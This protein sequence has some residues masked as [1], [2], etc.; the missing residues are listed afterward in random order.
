MTGIT[1]F[2]QKRVWTDMTF[3][4]QVMSIIHF[5]NNAVANFAE[6]HIRSDPKPFWR[7]RGTK[8]AIVDSGEN[9]TA[10]YE[11]EINH[12]SSGSLQLYTYRD[13]GSVHEQTLPYK[14]SDWHMFYRDI[15]AHLLAGAPV[16]ISGETGRRVIGIM[17]QSINSADAGHT[18]PPLFA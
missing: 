11:K 6:C 2:T 4:D 12:L 1:G 7:I 17:E 16:P 3:D 5:E 10:G 15:A 8:G 14:D 13:D 9:A 18:L